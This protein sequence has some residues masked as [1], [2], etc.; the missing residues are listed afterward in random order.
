MYQMN[1]GNHIHE[2]RAQQLRGSYTAYLR[3]PIAR[4]GRLE[5][6]RTRRRAYSFQRSA[7]VR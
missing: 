3:K 2:H 5:N 1:I 4:S 6:L 7:E